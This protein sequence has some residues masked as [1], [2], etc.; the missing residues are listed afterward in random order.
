MLAVGVTADAQNLGDVLSSVASRVSKVTSMTDVANVVGTA[1]VTAKQLVGTWS[2]SK[3]AVAFES[4]QLLSKAGGMV[5]ANTLETRLATE[6]ANYGI[7]AGTLKFTFHS[8]GR[9]SCSVGT[10]QI[11]GTY[12]VAGPA[13]TFAAEKSDVKVK[14]NAKVSATSLQLTFAA[15]K[16]LLLMQQFGA[17][18]GDA[19]LKA[20]ASMAKNYT[21]MQLG[22][23]LT[24][25]K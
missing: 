13:V 15:D 25:A 11:S 17:Q 20:I 5:V 7:K 18:T 9:Y 19:R 12:S 22:M 14:A 23:K 6:L 8:D 3:P 4:N 21:G 2:Y 24:R 16:L 1:S 10:R